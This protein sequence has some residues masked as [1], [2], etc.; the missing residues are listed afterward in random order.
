VADRYGVD[1]VVESFFIFKIPLDYKAHDLRAIEELNITPTNANLI[2]LFIFFEV[3]RV[4]VVV[5]QK[6][7]EAILTLRC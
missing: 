1:T 7:S 6:I 2:Q 3:A 4:T 5:A